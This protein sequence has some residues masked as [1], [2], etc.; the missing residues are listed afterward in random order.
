[1]QNKI[2]KALSAGQAEQASEWLLKVLAKE[3]PTSELLGQV[4]LI[5]QDL[6]DK[7]AAAETEEERLRIRNHYA[8]K[9]LDIWE[10]LDK[11]PALSKPPTTLTAPDN[12]VKLLIVLLALSLLLMLIEIITW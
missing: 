9:L 11:Q 5:R 7:I 2:F 10:Q 1:M 4:S 8:A 6:L 3:H 12:L